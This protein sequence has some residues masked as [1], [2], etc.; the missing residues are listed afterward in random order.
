MD[1]FIFIG[2]SWKTNRT[3]LKA[4]V[5]HTV[6]LHVLQLVSPD[7]LQKRY[8]LNSLKREHA[9]QT[10]VGAQSPLPSFFQSYV[11][12]LLRRGGGRCFLMY[13]IIP[14]SSLGDFQISKPVYNW[15]WL[16]DLVLGNRKICDLHCRAF[17]GPRRL[18]VLL[19]SPTSSICE[20][21]AVAASC[22]C[23][24]HWGSG[25]PFLSV[26]FYLVTLSTYLAVA[27]LNE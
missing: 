26:G 16:C 14:K 2:I 19:L 12:N 22:P 25:C 10:Q 9:L 13:D 6:K 21:L 11:Q 8:F 27:L 24:N 1:L 4:C 7:L 20:L 3:Y 23:A 18:R 15:D 5:M 17:F